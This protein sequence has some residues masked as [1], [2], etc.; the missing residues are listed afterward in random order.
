MTTRRSFLALA[1]ATGLSHR[2]HSQSAPTAANDRIEVALIGAGVRGKYLLG[3]L[4]SQARVTAICDCSLSQIDSATNPQGEFAQI[5]RNFAESDGL[6]CAK[7]QDYRSM[8]D[9]RSFD[10]VIVAAPDHHHAQAAI[11]AMQAGSHVYVE[12]PLAVT[13][14]EGR[15]IVAAA[16][17]Y[18][19]V[20]QVGSQQRSMQANRDACEFIRNG[21]L[22]RVLRVEERAFP[23][24]M[25]YESLMFPAQSVPQDM[26]WSAF[27]GP[28]PLRDYSRDL[29]MKDQYQK[30]DLLWRG[31]DLLRDYS[32]H[33]MTNW[34]AHSVDM[35]QYALNKDTTGPT[36]ISL[37]GNDPE[38][39]L[40]ECA[41]K[42][43]D[44]TPP[45]QTLT[46][47][48]HD[49]RRF[50]S[51]NMKYADGTEL[52]FSPKVTETT[53]YGEKGQLMLARNKYSTNPP[54]M[55][56]PISADELNKWS[57]SGHVAR[58]HLEDWLSAIETGRPVHAPPETGH[59]SASV[60]HL[61]NIAREVGEPLR[62]EPVSENFIGNAR[63]SE[64]L[65][66]PRRSGYELPI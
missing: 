41:E 39:S 28:T 15:A 27:C 13:I 24:P 2:V 56:P 20:V 55:L 35:I 18:D 1:A 47:P 64:L 37:V 25:P 61:A 38:L 6:S 8:L 34:G 53:F 59:R 14:D 30:G 3:N 45:L 54:N 26:D 66:R 10:A 29:W 12:K 19:R 17:K 40:A 33:I 31:W 16:A 49:H 48:V 58:P 5:L 51:V 4:P 11:L 23:G 7:F 63:A 46:D 32:G 43:R 36:E 42:W 52:L 50:W 21:G 60:C 62:W 65:A 9:E 57:G 44:K 22:G